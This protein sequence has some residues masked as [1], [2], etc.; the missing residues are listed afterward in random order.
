MVKK[1]DYRSNACGREGR[2]PTPRVTN[3]DK[4][5]AE[6]DHAQVAEHGMAGVTGMRLA[7]QLAASK[8]SMKSAVNK[9]KAYFWAL[10]KGVKGSQKVRSDTIGEA[11][12]GRE[13][14]NFPSITRGGGRGSCVFERR[15][16]EVRRPIFE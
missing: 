14:A 12:G 5:K 2:N 9:L 4:E 3:F 7:C 11:G 15:Q 8:A 13:H 6:A 10:F 16:H 1:M